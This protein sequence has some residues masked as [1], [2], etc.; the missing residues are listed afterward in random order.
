MFLT[1][2]FDKCFPESVKNEKENEFIQSKQGSITISQYVVKFD[3][4]SKFSFYLKNNPD[5][6]WEAT[7]FE[8][9]L[10]PKIREKVSTLE[11]KNFATLVNKCR[12]AKKSFP[13][14]GV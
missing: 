8:W 2:F 10:K 4:L 9:G 11:I 6:R 5:S 1:T 12:I 3:E 14:G 13:G 7:K